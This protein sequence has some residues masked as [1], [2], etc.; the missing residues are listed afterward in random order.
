MD[1]IGNETGDAV[2]RFLLYVGLYSWRKVGSLRLI[3]MKFEAV[4]LRCRGLGRRGGLRCRGRGLLGSRAVR[5]LEVSGV[6]EAVDRM[7]S[8]VA[9]RE[10]VGLLLSCS[11]KGTIGPGPGAGCGRVAS[12]R[13]RWGRR[14]DSR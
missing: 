1:G 6:L 5:G 4:R 9:G 13:R 14:V 3:L 11:F 7:E 2:F 12:G 8:T 10:V